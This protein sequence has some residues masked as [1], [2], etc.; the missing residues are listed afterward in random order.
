[1]A[2]EIAAHRYTIQIDIS[3]RMAPWCVEKKTSVD[4]F[5][6]LSNKKASSQFAT[7]ATTKMVKFYKS[8]G[9]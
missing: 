6:V 8:K 5:R 7:K 9:F 1:M 2:K 3:T 4:D